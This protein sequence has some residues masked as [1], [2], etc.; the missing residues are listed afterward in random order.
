ME[1]EDGKEDRSEENINT[2]IEDPTRILWMRWLGGRED[3]SEGKEGN[4]GK[5]VRKGNEE[6]EEERNI[7]GRGEGIEEERNVKSIV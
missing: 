7:G 1:E 3:R 6:E 5:R 2:R 4:I